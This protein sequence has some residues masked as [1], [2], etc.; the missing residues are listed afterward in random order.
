MKKELEGQNKKRVYRKVEYMNKNESTD[1]DE[2]IN[3]SL[4]MNQKVGPI[5]NSRK[6]DEQKMNAELKTKIEHIQDEVERFSHNIDYF[7]NICDTE[8]EQLLENIDQVTK[9]I[10]ELRKNNPAVA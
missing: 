2:I 9:S 10:T 6:K 8:L 5:L 7:S 3:E 1:N 4:N